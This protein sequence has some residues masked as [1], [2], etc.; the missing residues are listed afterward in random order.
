MGQIQL[1]AHRGAASRL[2][3]ELVASVDALEALRAPWRELLPLYPARQLFLTPAWVCAWWR[4]FGGDFA[5]RTLALRDDGRLVALGVFMLRSLRLRG[6]PIRVFGTLD[7]E[8]VSRSDLIVAPGYEASA[9]QGLAEFLADSAA[10][11]DVCWLQQLPADA[12]WLQPFLDAAREL[13]LR[14]SAPRDGL[15]KCRMPLP[16]DWQ[17]F[18]EARGGH[19]RRNVGKLFRRVERAGRIAWRHSLNPMPADSDFAA[20]A[21]VEAQSWKDRDEAGARLGRRGW[22]FQQEFATAYDE[23]VSCESWIVDFDGRPAAIVHSVGYE[24]VSYCFQTLFDQRVRDIHLGRAAVTRHFQH[25]FDCGRYDVL[26]LNGNSA[27]CRSWCG[28]EQRF[29]SVELHNRRPRSQA[30]WA[31]RRL[32]GWS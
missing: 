24:R 3:P 21:A 17:T 29:V 6:L 31:L 15:G 5:L 13:G 2:Q 30:L 14:A 9:A 8:H 22:A 18:L 26:D 32:R 27:F 20:F 4:A 19:F 12:A 1:K 16:A 11:W 28:T 7:N 23:G 10:D 25:V